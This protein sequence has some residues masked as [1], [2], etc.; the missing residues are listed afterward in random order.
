MKLRVE[1]H[2][3]IKTSLYDKLFSSWQNDALVVDEQIRNCSQ[4]YC[5]YYYLIL[6]S[7]KYGQ[8]RKQTEN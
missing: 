8:Q 7:G 2:Q 1:Q 3:T 5:T 6:K 4:K